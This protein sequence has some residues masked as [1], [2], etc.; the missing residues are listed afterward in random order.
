ME[1]QPVAQE[2]DR[3][4]VSLGPVLV[5]DDCAPVRECLLMILGL[6]GYEAIGAEDGKTALAVMRQ[7]RPG[8]VLL[9]LMMPGLSGWDVLHEMRQMP[10]TTDVPVVTLTG[11]SDMETEN[12]SRREGAVHHLAKPVAPDELLAVVDTTLQLT[13]PA[14]AS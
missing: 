14:S 10:S 3:E 4:T 7:R 1:L 5:V 11:L 6:S 12:R 8:M 9:D 2:C 13:P